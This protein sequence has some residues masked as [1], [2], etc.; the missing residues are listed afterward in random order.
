MTLFQRPFGAHLPCR[1]LPHF[2]FCDDERL[3]MQ[4]INLDSNQ[5]PPPRLSTTCTSHPS[6]RE[7]AQEAFPETSRDLTGL[8]ERGPRFTTWE[9][10]TFGSPL[11]PNATFSCCAF[12]ALFSSSLLHASPNSIHIEEVVAFARTFPSFLPGSVP[13]APVAPFCC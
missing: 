4:H 1:A 11:A 12:A 10:L 8:A 7:L 6:S 13:F 9:I 3:G 5:L 2:S